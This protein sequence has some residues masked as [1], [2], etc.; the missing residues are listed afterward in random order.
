[1]SR[2]RDRYRINP[3]PYNPDY[4]FDLNESRAHFDINDTEG[5]N[6]QAV[7]LES[8]LTQPDFDPEVLELTG[9]N[10]PDSFKEHRSTSNPARNNKLSK[11]GTPTSTNK[12]QVRKQF[13]RLLSGIAYTFALSVLLLYY[14][15]FIPG[16]S[17]FELDELSRPGSFEQDQEVPSL[18]FDSDSTFD[19]V[20][21]DEAIQN[22]VERDQESA[23]IFHNRLTTLY[24]AILTA[25]AGYFEALRR[26]RI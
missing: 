2:W 3:P 12:S 16:E 14:L 1:M 13:S 9:R 10:L 26:H 25:I 22:I 4:S 5:N 24:V 18:F 17:D 8:N 21:V 7:Q 6:S 20:T 23:Q 15:N 19:E 11:K